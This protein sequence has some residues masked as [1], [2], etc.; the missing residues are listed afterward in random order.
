M[1]IDIKDILSWGFGHIKEYAYNQDLEWIL[2][3]SGKFQFVINNRNEIIFNNLLN[4]IIIVPN[5]FKHSECVLINQ[6]K[7]F[8]INTSK[9]ENIEYNLQFQKTERYIHY[10]KNDLSNA[11]INSIDNGN[12]LIVFDEEILMV[13]NTIL[14]KSEFILNCGDDITSLI[15]KRTAALFEALPDFYN[16][17][18]YGISPDKLVVSDDEQYFYIISA[19]EGK[20]LMVFDL[21]DYTLCYNE[22]GSYAIEFGIFYNEY[23]VLPSGYDDYDKTSFRTINLR[24]GQKK[25][26]DKH[27]WDVR[28]GIVNDDYLVLT[29]GVHDEELLNA[30]SFIMALDLNRLVNDNELIELNIDVKIKENDFFDAAFITSDSVYFASHKLVSIPY[31]VDIN[32]PHPVQRNNI[33]IKV[34]NDKIA[35]DEL[36]EKIVKASFSELTIAEI[37][38]LINYILIFKENNYTQHWQVNQ[39]ISQKRMWDS[40]KDI[41]SYNDHGYKNNIKGILPKYFSIVCEVLEIL[42][43]DGNPLLDAKS[44]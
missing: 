5:T 13:Y 18:F 19:A 3:E 8:S 38:Q 42:G 43:D 26:N 10:Q 35:N 4:Q 22:I 41:R 6:N 40:F 25:F 17:K 16:L 33:Q 28:K 9:I 39:K 12:K 7:V 32:T 14:D 24:N 20:D 23:F 1:K 36:K 44:Y 27:W 34:P 30:D 31:K 21:S 15:N 2:I 11:Y 29:G 37:E